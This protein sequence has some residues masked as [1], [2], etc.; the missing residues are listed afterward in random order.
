MK[1]FYLKLDSKNYIID[2]IEYAFLNYINIETQELPVDILSGYYKFENEMF[3]VDE[4][5]KTQLEKTLQQPSNV[6]EQRI[7][8]LEE[9]NKALLVSQEEQDALIMELMIGGM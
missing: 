3:V 2:V 8:Q 1:Q 5:K 6:V 9:E 7:A 4:V